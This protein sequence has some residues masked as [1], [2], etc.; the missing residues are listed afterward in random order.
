[1]L[2]A[3]AVATGLDSMPASPTFARHHNGIACLCLGAT[4]CRQQH[5]AFNTA[6]SQ[7]QSYYAWVACQAH[8][9]HLM[10]YRCRILRV[11]S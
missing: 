1:M 4:P 2:Q 6:A 9:H 5:V 11:A 7:K 10:L 3:V 8:C